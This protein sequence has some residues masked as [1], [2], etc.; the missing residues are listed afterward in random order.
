MQ[1]LI[2]EY[3]KLFSKPSTYVVLILVP[4][5]FVF[6]NLVFFSS[7][8]TTKLSIGVYSKDRSPLSKFTVGVVVSLF[9]GGTIKYVDENYQEKLRSG[10]LNAVV[11]IPEDF[12]SSLF[13]GKKTKLKYIPSPINT[14]LSV[15][16][17]IVFRQMFEDLGGGPFF[18]PKVLREMYTASNVPAPE[19]TTDKTLDFSHA[20]APSMI[21]I[22]TMFVGLVIGSG[23]ISREKEAGIFRLLA[24]SKI[25]ISSYFFLKFLVLFS[26]STTSG[27]ISYLIFY[28]LGL[29][30]NF[31]YFLILVPINAIFYTLFGLLISVLAP[32]SLSSNLIGSTLA[33]VFLLSS[34]TLVSVNQIPESFKHFVTY[35]IIYKSTYI[36]RNIQFFGRSNDV[37]KLIFEL[38]SFSI[39]SSLIICVISIIALFTCLGPDNLPGV[40][41]LWT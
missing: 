31:I 40:K 24:L 30:I 34:G 33:V 28:F 17:Y 27:L 29:K 15:A 4:F 37:I 20:F 36:V 32:N 9:R 39:I 6:I 8:S 14:E 3:K 2:F 11:V 16:A 41:N 5:I 23:L 38:L 19:L 21:F 25:K 26:L 7:V 1:L 35:S 18:N 12:T 22:V 10:E 13:S